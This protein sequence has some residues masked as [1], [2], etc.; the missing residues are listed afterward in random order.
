MTNAITPQAPTAP[1]ER[2]IPLDALRGFAVLGI[3]IMNIQSYS[4]IEAAYI[5]P[6]AYGDLTGINRWVSVLSHLFADGKFMAIFSILFGAGVVLM[7]RKV[8][9]KGQS[10][11]GLHYR[12]TFWLIVIGM[13]HAYLLWYGDILTAYG[14]CALLIFLFRKISPKWLLVIGLISASVSSLIYL[15]FGFSLPYWPAEAHQNVLQAWRPSA[16]TVAQE[17]SSYQGSWLEQMTHR[18]PA[19]LMFQTFL[20]V[21]WVGWR[22]GGLMLVGMALFKWGLLT[23]QRSKRF[24]STLAG[25]GFGLGLPLVIYGMVCNYQA[26]WSFDYSMFIGNQF[27]YWGSILIAVGYIST[28]MLLCQST[29]LQKL[30]SR[31]AAVG[32]MALTNYLMQT[33][34]CTTIFYGHGLGLFGQIERSGQILIVFG[35]WVFQLWVSPIWLRYFRFGPAEWIWRFLTYLRLQPMR[36]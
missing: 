1:S 24:Y 13:I 27:N 32:R 20:F 4:M 10:S 25:I 8:E 34:I 19:A 11:A 6:T 12:R 15:S 36:R 3:L 31:F 30:V 22:A 2:I 33:M 26:N 14:V 16:Q 17:I 35:V 18:A 28:V 9:A 7:T 29:R 23:A 5:N 21:I